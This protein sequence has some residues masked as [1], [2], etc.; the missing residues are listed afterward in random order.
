MAKRFRWSER[1]FTNAQHFTNFGAS[2]FMY[3][4]AAPRTQAQMQRHV[5]SCRKCARLV[6]EI[7]D[8]INVARVAFRW[9]LNRPRRQVGRS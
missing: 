6:K 8:V 4:D 1:L 7:K 2:V 5:H 3:K 9:A